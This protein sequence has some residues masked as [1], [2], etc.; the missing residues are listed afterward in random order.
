M[1]EAYFYWQI[2][3]CKD[4]LYFGTKCNDKTYAFLEYFYWRWFANDLAVKNDERMLAD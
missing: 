1:F 2:D 3:C 4:G